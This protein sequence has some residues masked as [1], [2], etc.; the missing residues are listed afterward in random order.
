MIAEP[1]ETQPLDA[2]IDNDDDNDGYETVYI[3]DLDECVSYYNWLDDT[4]ATSHITNQCEA[5]TKFTP[6]E[7]K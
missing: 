5:F 6:L 3:S 4:C 7:K 2:K 1:E